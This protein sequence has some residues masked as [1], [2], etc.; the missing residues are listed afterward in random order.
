[1][2]REGWPSCAGRALDCIAPKPVQTNAVITGVALLLAVETFGL[3]LSALD[4]AMLAWPFNVN[5]CDLLLREQPYQQPLRLRVLGS[6]APG[7]L[8]RGMLESRYQIMVRYNHPPPIVGATY[9]SPERQTR[10]C[11]DA[12]KQL[13]FVYCI[14]RGARPF[15]AISLSRY[16]AVL[17]KACA[18]ETLGPDCCGCRCLRVASSPTTT[19]PNRT[20]QR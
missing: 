19:F 17:G 15:A 11:T 2:S 1:M 12:P 14:D 8:G 5:T 6:G 10:A 3:L 16:R 13:A 20:N 7:F 4:L 18:G 9:S